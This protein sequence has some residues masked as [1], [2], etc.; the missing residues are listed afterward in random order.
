MQISLLQ[1][2]LYKI[3]YEL[4]YGKAEFADA[5]QAKLNL[6]L[7]QMLQFFE[8]LYFRQRQALN[9]TP[10]FHKTVQLFML[11]MEQVGLLTLD[12][13]DALSV[14]LCSEP[15]AYLMQDET[16]SVRSSQIG[17]NARLRESNTKLKLAGLMPLSGKEVQAQSEP[18][19]RQRRESSDSNDTTAQQRATM[20][21][22]Q[23][24]GDLMESDDTG[25]RQA[26]TNFVAGGPVRIFTHMLLHVL[27]YSM[28]DVAGFDAGLQML[29]YLILR[30]RG[31]FFK[32]VVS[33]VFGTNFQTAPVSLYS[34]F[35]R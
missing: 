19:P 4:N 7:I 9:L 31:T 8:E 21:T 24:Q 2:V 3:I 12:A 23:K 25:L 1:S 30:K 29:E 16:S 14:I 22:P 32:L 33:E 34:L 13:P 35:S 28:E 15:A 11:L 18:R 6:K 10:E 17:S 5:K 26:T 27:H 20:L